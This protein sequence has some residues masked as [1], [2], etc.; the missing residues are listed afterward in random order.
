MLLFKRPLKPIDFDAKVL[1]SKQKIQDII[2]NNELPK[3][4]DFN[5]E[6]SNF[7]SV[8]AKQQIHKCGYCEIHVLACQH[9]DVDHYYP[10]TLINGLLE[11]GLEIED[12]NNVVGRTFFNISNMGYW[13]MAYDWNNYL[14][15]CQTCNQKWKINLFPVVN[16][17]LPLSHMNY[18][19]ERPLIL[20]PYGRRKPSSHLKYGRLGEIYTK[21][22]SRFGKET[23][24][25][26]GLNRPTLRLARRTAAKTI[27]NLITELNQNTTDD[28]YKT[29]AKRIYDLGNE[30]AYF[31]GMIRIIF[32]NELRM[33]WSDLEKIVL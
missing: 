4:E 3:S 26:C 27:F 20:N 22:Y 33:K 18:Q 24:Q 6:W 7:K 19:D 23:I 25:V 1:L 21:N 13:W 5:N 15:S 17:V 2:D 14:L 11:E 8:L 12:S 29:T 10:K 16:R 31:P 28:Q 9:G 30:E 32:E